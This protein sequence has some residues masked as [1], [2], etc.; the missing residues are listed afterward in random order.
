M[1][2]K[3]KAA[4]QVRKR[5]AHQACRVFLVF[6]REVQFLTEDNDE[7]TLTNILRAGLFC[8]ASASG[9]STLFRFL[10]RL[11]GRAT[12]LEPAGSGE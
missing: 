2:L 12:W 8:S 4:D 3:G 7:R 5:L 11:C 1:V 9:V 10:L 6:P